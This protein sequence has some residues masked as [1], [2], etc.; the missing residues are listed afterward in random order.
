MEELF[1]TY[2]FGLIKPWE[3]KPHRTPPTLLEKERRVDNL[4]QN[5]QSCYET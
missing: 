1:E 2:R 3:S 5:E 4:G